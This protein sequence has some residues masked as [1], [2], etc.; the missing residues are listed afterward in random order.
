VAVSSVF[1]PKSGFTA[2]VFFGCDETLRDDITGRMY[3]AENATSHPLLIMGIL[4]E[5]EFKRHSILVRDQ[6]FQLLGRIRALSSQVQITTD[7]TMKKDHYSVESWY[8][9][10]Q[11][12]SELQ[13]WKVQLAHMVEH[14]DQ[15]EKEV[16]TE[17]S[18]SSSSTFKDVVPDSPSSDT[19]QVETDDLEEVDEKLIKQHDE[20]TSTTDEVDWRQ[21]G[22]QTG[23]RIK[24]RLRVIMNEYDQKI[25]ECTMVI[26]GLILATQ[27][28]LTP[29]HP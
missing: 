3:S 28:V 29:I 7:S 18:Y 11:L 6:V 26:D 10:S 20:H 12:R 25:R 17:Q 5:I 19:T 8:K 4:A 27:M 13:T 14:I 22:L 15:L 2:A 23:R 24:S 16:F 21:H 1:Y 9:I